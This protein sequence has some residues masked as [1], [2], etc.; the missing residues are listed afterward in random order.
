M[1]IEHL[2]GLPTLAPR[3]A[4]MLFFILF[5]AYWLA[6]GFWSPTV[7]SLQKAAIAVMAAVLFS[8]VSHVWPWYIIW[9]LALTVLVP[10]W[11]LS[12]FVF[13]LSLLMPFALAA[14]WIEPVPNHME[15][16]R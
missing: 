5:A 8:G 12:R 15:L 1:A 4:A 6:V 2:T 11:W 9:L 3:M 13:G 7:T 16:L 10:G 14:W